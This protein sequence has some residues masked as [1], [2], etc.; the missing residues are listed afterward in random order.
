MPV[1]CGYSELVRFLLCLKHN[2]CMRVYAADCIP[3]CS[4]CVMARHIPFVMATDRL[5]FLPT[6][7]A[8]LAGESHFGGDILLTD[9]QRATMEATANVKDP[10]APQNA[11]VRR[12]RYTWAGG[13]VPYAIDDSL[14]EA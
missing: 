14:G 7:P 1:S 13:V 11:V 5:L 10:F 9:E 8:E 2:G 3:I 4:S 6:S 12:V